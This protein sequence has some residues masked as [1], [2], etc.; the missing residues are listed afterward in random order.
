[1]LVTADGSVDCMLDPGE[2][3]VFV[4]HLQYCELITALSVLNEGDAFI[5]T[6][7]FVF[8]PFFFTGGTFLIKMFTFFEDS[9]TCLLYLLNHSFQNVHVSKPSASKSGNSEVYVICLNFKGIKH[10]QHFWDDLLLPYKSPESKTDKSLFNIDEIH[11]SFVK[12]ISDCADFFMERQ[13]ETIEENIKHYGKKEK[14]ELAKIKLRKNLVAD[15][16]IKKCKLQAIAR[17]K[18]LVN[19]VEDLNHLSFYFRQWNYSNDWSFLE[20]FTEF[21]TSA[22][23]CDRKLCNILTLKFGKPLKK[24]VH[25]NFCSKD[26]QKLNVTEFLGEDVLYLM[27]LVQ[28]FADVNDNVLNVLDYTNKTKQHDMH[29]SFFHSIREKLG[30]NQLIFIKIPFVTSFLVSILYLLMFN[31]ETAIFHKDGFIVLKNLSSRVEEVRE[32]FDVI[33]STF[34]DVTDE[35]GCDKE[36][37]VNQIVPLSVMYDRVFI[38]LVWNYNNVVCTQ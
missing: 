5:C 4:E 29:V 13:I 6:T 12:Q 33:Y 22:L 19:S 28:S 10:L 24:V 26:N 11:E 8:L 34:S 21:N 3:E 32:C 16:Y 35:S 7:S 14:A 20:E 38:D 17:E 37:D 9:S 30:N 18:R 2:Q 25:S 27:E 15:R 31:Y 1:M 23:N 36:L